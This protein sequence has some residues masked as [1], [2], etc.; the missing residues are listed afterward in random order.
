[1]L[2]WNLLISLRAT[3]PGLNL[4]GFLTPPVAA[5]V[6][7]FF[8]CLWAMCFLGALPPVFFLAVCLVLAILFMIFVF[9]ELL[10]VYSISN[11][12]T[13][14]NSISSSIGSYW[15]MCNICTISEDSEKFRI[16]KNR[17][18]RIKWYTGSL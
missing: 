15:L 4:C 11:L 14:S 13:F 17:P 5:W 2:F 12:L 16:L 7:D 3:V 18:K 8:A 6:D 9:L 1:M 10:L